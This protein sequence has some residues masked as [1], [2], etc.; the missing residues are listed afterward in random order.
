ML[1]PDPAHEFAD[2]YDSSQVD[3]TRR[4]RREKTNTLEIGCQAFPVKTW[5]SRQNNYKIWIHSGWVSRF[6]LTNFRDWAA[7]SARR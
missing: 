3:S 5:S 2:E 6:G 1:D 4:V 7:I